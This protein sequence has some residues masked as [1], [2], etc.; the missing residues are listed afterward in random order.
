MV[1]F[2]YGRGL[3]SGSAT[4][5]RGGHGITAWRLHLRALWT[6]TRRPAAPRLGRPP[7]H[8]LTGLAARNSRSPARL[9]HNESGTLPLISTIRGEK[10]EIKYR[11]RTRTPIA[12]A[13]P[14]WS[15][16]NRPPNLAASPSMA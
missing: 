4:A 9:H 16:S 6:T 14:T 2:A 5:Q 12:V 13:G 11:P 15:D 10:E 8:Q 1:R 7:T 3:V